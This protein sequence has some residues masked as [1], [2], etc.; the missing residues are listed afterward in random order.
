L[1]T[2]LL[3]RILPELRA[4]EARLAT[5]ALIAAVLAEYERAR[6]PSDAP[7]PA[8]ETSGSRWRWGATAGWS[9]P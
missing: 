9:R 1:S 7:P 5:I 3:E 6:R 4:N 8:A 2:A